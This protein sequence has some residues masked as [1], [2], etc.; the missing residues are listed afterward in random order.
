MV[1]PRDPISPI[2]RVNAVFIYGSIIFI[3]F[4]NRRIIN[5]AIL[6][7]WPL[8]VFS[9]LAF[10]SCLW[11]PDF[12][13][14]LRRSIALLFNLLTVAALVAL[15][16]PVRVVRVFALALGVSILCSIL[17]VVLFPRY[18]L[19]TAA[20]WVEPVHAGLWRGV[21]THKNS[22]GSISC[23]ALV[24]FLF[25]G[26]SVIKSAIFRVAAI[27]S[28]A[29]C[30]IGAKSGTGI[31][32]A[33]IMTLVIVFFKNLTRMNKSTRIFFSGF[34]LIAVALIIAAAVPVTYFVL[35]ALGKSPDF[36][37]RIP[38]WTPLIAW[39]QERPWLGFGYSTGF[40]Q[41]MM[42]R[43]QEYMRLS[44]SSA[45]NGY[46]ET[47]ISFG[48]VGIALLMFLIISFLGKM[49]VGLLLVRQDEEIVLPFIAGLFFNALFGNF[50][51]SLFLMQNS[52]FNMSWALAY[53]M[54]A[55]WTRSRPSMKPVALRSSAES[56]A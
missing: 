21:Y 50:T 9:A 55:S 33:V 8:F 56:L 29:A 31:V 2:A 54:I 49:V 51:E 16:P 45:H 32:L 23:V 42:P 43:L 5:A 27:L 28:A 7:S 13:T 20:D 19:H 26:K 40:E 4:S 38:I 48:Y 12:A 1:T 14:T 46:L 37:G 18:G 30:L 35:D 34:G 3:Y 44:I 36:T 53:I 10:L 17:W 6:A 15:L 39:G 47:F 24:V 25:F 52:F 11:A 22:L 41:G